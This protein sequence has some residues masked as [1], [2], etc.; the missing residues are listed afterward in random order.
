MGS[1]PG[2]LWFQ[3][4]GQHHKVGFDVSLTVHL[5]IIL[6][7]DQPDAQILIYLL[8]SSTYICFE[9][10]LTHPQEVKSY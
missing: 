6:A 4:G 1:C 3:S 5:S 2:L 10:Y 7:N 8:H 9:Q